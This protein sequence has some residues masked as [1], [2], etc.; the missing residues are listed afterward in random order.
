MEDRDN[1]NHRTVASRRLSRNRG[2]PILISR[3]GGILKR[4]TVT[5]QCLRVDSRFQ[6]VTKDHNVT[7]RGVTIMQLWRDEEARERLSEVGQVI[8]FSTEGANSDRLRTDVEGAE[9]PSKAGQGYGLIAV[10]GSRPGTVLE[11]AE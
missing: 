9:A 4:D 8:A 10:V 1:Q 11:S 2:Q 5:I 3:A 7:L 6:G